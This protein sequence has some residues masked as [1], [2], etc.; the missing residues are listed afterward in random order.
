MINKI[1]SKNVGLARFHTNVLMAA[2]A[3]F[4]SA[5]TT[6]PDQTAKRPGTMHGESNHAEP[7]TAAGQDVPIKSAPERPK[8]ELTEEILYK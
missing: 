5:C 2:L 6:L 4:I 1:V 8:I 3:L 7:T